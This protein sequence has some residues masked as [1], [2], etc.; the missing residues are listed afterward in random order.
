MQQSMDPQLRAPASSNPFVSRA[1][2]ASSLAMAWN[3]E[4]S[5]FHYTTGTMLCASGNVLC[6][7]GL[8]FISPAR[9]SPVPHPHTHTLPLIIIGSNQDSPPFLLRLCLFSASEGKH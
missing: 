5:D 8:G 2:S 3:T 4:H 1:S 9:P 6:Q 7:D